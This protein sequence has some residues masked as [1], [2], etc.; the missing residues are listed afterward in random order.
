M[1]VRFEPMAHSLATTRHIIVR[2]PSSNRWV[3]KY[4]SWLACIFFHST[5]LYISLTL[6]PPS[7]TFFISYLVNNTT[8][9]IVCSFLSVVLIP[10]RLLLPKYVA[11]HPA[12]H[13][14]HSRSLTSHSTLNRDF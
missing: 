7:Y 6:Y 12:H 4:P 2:P 3:Y 5:Q 11:Y 8:T 13:I 9:S 14:F 1:N 10:R